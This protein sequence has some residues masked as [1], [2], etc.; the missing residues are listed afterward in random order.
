[1]APARLLL[2]AALLLALVGG[3]AALAW[4]QQGGEGA[5]GAYE[6]VVLGP[7]GPLYHGHATVEDATALGALRAAAREAGLDVETEEYPGMGTYVRAVG[8][9]RADGPS[10]WVY[11]VRHDGVW[12]YGDRSAAYAPLQPGDAVRWRW[13]AA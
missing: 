6:V 4:W 10:G 9:H 8:P 11:E 3:A 2:A 5:P 1:M 12:T 13:K 7:D